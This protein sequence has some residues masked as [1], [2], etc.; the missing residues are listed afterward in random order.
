MALKKERSQSK[1][2]IYTLGTSDNSPEEFVKLLRE[3]GVEVEADVRR[4][5]SSRFPHFHREALAEMVRQ[6]GLDYVYLGGELGG[7]RS[8]GY[9]G[10]MLS[11]EFQRGIEQLE[12]MAGEKTVAV[13]CAERLPWKC[14]RRFI[15]FEL[16]ERGW[17]SHP[18]H[19]PQAH[20]AVSGSAG[21]LGPLG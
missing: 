4:F 8:G 13:V 1:G 5:P 3:Y 15:G 2:P 20:L 7:C 14:H 19:R 12:Q 11:A 16:M 17:Q 21:A 18:H 9:E 6:A 10:Y